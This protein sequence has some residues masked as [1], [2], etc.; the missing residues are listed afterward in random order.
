MSDYEI[1]STGFEIEYNSEFR[2][3]HSALAN[4]IRYGIT[5]FLS[6]FL[7]FQIQPMIAKFILPWFG[8]TAAVWTTCMMFFQITLLLGYLYAHL[9]RRIFS[10]QMVWR[11]H[12]VILILACAAVL[13]THAVPPEFL[14]PTGGENLTAA[15]VKLLAITVGLPF[16]V[17]SATGPLV[18]AWH[19]TSHGGQTYRLYAV[20]N[21]GSML[22]LLTYP[23][24]FERVFSL[25]VQ[26]LIWTVGF[27]LF[28]TLCC[29]SGLQTASQSKWLQTEHE[30]DQS[31]SNETDHVGVGLLLAWIG[32]AMAPSVMLIATTNLMSQEVASIPFLWI[33]P[34]TLYLLSLIICFDRPSLYRRAV[35]TPLLIAS[36]IVSILI[37]HVSNQISLLPQIIGLAIVCFSCSM[38]C[39]GELERLKPAPN[40]LTLFY[41]MVS[42]GGALGGIFVVAIAP[43]IFNDFC[44][45][46]IGLFACLFLTVGVK[47]IEA[48]HQP[49]HNTFSAWLSAV[50]ALVAAGCV[51]SSL[52]YF[53]DFGYEKGL[54]TFER[55]EYGLVSVREKN[56]YRIMVNG[57]TEHGGQFLEGPEKMQPSSYYVQGSGPSIAIQA[58]RSDPKREGRGLNI[59]V[60]GLGTGSLV[61]WGQ[62]P[63]KFWFYE[64]N[65]LAEKLA[66]EYFT[67]LEES[68]DQSQ[69]I[70]GDGRIQLE[71]QLKESGSLNLDVLFMDAFTS[72][73]IPAH[74]LTRE[75]FDLYWKHL[76]PDGILV[77][78][79]TNRFVDLRPVIHALAVERGHTPILINHIHG[80]HQTRWVLMTRNAHV[81]ESEMVTSVQSTWPSDMEEIFWTDDFASLAQL[82]DWS[83]KLD[84][85]EETPQPPANRNGK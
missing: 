11:V 30:P 25:N 29:W 16:L 78:H 68:K 63:D 67:Y 51:L 37:L 64:I 49:K 70:L 85:N 28:A 58:L 4:M 22:A 72:D 76:K 66:R 23:F 9:V 81:I 55:N 5:I 43:R 44:E 18:Q 65:P 79:I 39:H 32:L 3:P 36:T 40:H 56:G 62:P 2:N 77:A 80:D 7:L 52:I 41:L 45:F 71:R 38:S 31:K 46:H 59:G 83:I 73:S 75:S 17:L 15:V 24:F 14:K 27:V 21:F 33:L 54:L 13:A 12:L 61:T 50:G 60:I 84:W 26:S 48:Y 53:I 35:F 20:S 42:L 69:V 34:L 47:V 6:A 19:S 82:V 1:S 10:P 74:L 8:G 57:R